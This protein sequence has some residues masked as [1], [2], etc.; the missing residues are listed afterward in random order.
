MCVTGLTAGDDQ[1][2]HSTTVRCDLQTLD[3]GGGRVS[4]YW[5][6]CSPSV[7]LSCIVIEEIERELQRSVLETAG[8]RGKA[9]EERKSAQTGA[10]RMSDVLFQICEVC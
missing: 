2:P 9:G 1:S 4:G 10:S 5:S 8:E 6:G 3:G 7:F